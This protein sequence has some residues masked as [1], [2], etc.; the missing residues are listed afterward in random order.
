MLDHLSMRNAKVWLTVPRLL[1]LIAI[2][3]AEILLSFKKL[4]S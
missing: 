2:V 3:P 4:L 1:A